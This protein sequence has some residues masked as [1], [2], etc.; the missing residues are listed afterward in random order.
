MPLYRSSGAWSEAYTLPAGNDL[1]PEETLVPLASELSERGEK[2][3]PRLG[4]GKE[5]Q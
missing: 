5:G 1:F 2:R 4:T 3:N